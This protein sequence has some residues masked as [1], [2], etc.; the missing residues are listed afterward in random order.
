MSHDKNMATC[1]TKDACKDFCKHHTDNVDVHIKYDPYTCACSIPAESIDGS[2][3]VPTAND[4]E[5]LCS[6]SG[7]ESSSFCLIEID[8]IAVKCECSFSDS[9]GNP[10]DCKKQSMDSPAE[11]L[12]ASCCVGNTA[13]PY[14]CKSCSF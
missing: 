2:G 14:G 13:I 1:P 5:K 3:R 12:G 6:K 9:S 11:D 4:C 10:S 7:G 8:P